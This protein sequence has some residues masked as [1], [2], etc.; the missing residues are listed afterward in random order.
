MRTINKSLSLAILLILG[1]I[2]YS[3]YCERINLR[4][5][6][7]DPPKSDAD[8]LFMQFV[9]DFNKQ[10]TSS[11]EYNF[12]REI[13]KRNLQIFNSQKKPTSDSYT[14]GPNFFADQ[15]P[16]EISS[17]FKYTSRQTLQS[18]GDEQSYKIYENVARPASKDWRDLKAVSPVKNQGYCGSNWAYAGASALESSYFVITRKDPLPILSAQ[19]LTDC[20]PTDKTNGCGAFQ[21]VD[22]VF[23]Y[24]TTS[25]VQL[26]S[27]YPS[28][29][30]STGKCNADLTK[31]V[32]Q[33]T[34]QKFVTPNNQEQLLQAILENPVLAEVNADLEFVFYNS[35]ILDSDVCNAP[36][37]QPVLIVGYGTDADTK[38]TYYIVK[39]SWGE[40]WGEKGYAR[41][42]SKPGVG[43]CG[44]HSR[45]SFYIVNSQSVQES[46]PSSQIDYSL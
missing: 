15:T 39:N 45:P 19:Q 17:R 29:G 1:L 5:Y 22:D 21:N 2:S 36:V 13:F 6:L 34:Y 9:S 23:T 24:A 12:R 41:I 46:N 25:K 35:G 4:P 40:S 30:V 27:D 26:E 20:L 3:V 28:T 38:V 14:I 16:A 32:V 44:I 42:A 11:T 8:K 31:G 10:Y 7:I 33:S 18:N 37:I 43:V